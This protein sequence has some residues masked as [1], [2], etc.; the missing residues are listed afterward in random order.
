[1][2]TN[3]AARPNA[4]AVAGVD[5]DRNIARTLSVEEKVLV[6][7]NGRHFPSYE[8]N[9]NVGDTWT[10]VSNS[11]AFLVLRNRQF[12]ITLPYDNATDWI[13]SDGGEFVSFIISD[14]HLA[15]KVGVQPLGANL[16]IILQTV[17]HYIEPEQVEVMDERPIEFIFQDKSDREFIMSIWREVLLKFNDDSLY[18]FALKSLVS[19]DD[20]IDI[21]QGKYDEID[22]MKFYL[23]NRAFYWMSRSGLALC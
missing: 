11:N 5:V 1:M 22:Y 23:I 12:I 16:Y 9:I 14:P 6:E 13:E 15:L 2:Y 8:G 4:V 10:V 18:R 17:S 20:I 3:D 19:L 21:K 7:I